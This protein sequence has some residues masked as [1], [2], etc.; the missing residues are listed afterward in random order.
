MAM[1]IGDQVRPRLKRSYARAMSKPWWRV[2]DRAIPPARYT[3]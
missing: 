2:T 1:R 3:T